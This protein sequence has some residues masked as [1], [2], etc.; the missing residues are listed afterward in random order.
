[1]SATEATIKLL[2]EIR[3]ELRK[4]NRGKSA[5]TTSAGGAG[6]DVADD[7]DLDSQYGDPEVK[8]DP[9]RWTGDR[10]AP[11]RMSE[12]SPDWLDALAGFCDWRAA[13]DD[14]SDALDTKGRPKSHWARKDAARAR[15][16]AARLR[17]SGGKPK[18]A[19]ATTLPNNGWGDSETSEAEAEAQAGQFDDV[20]F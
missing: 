13:K 10:F 11:C 4:L 5:A 20:G 16:W 18:P 14:E 8:K 19:Q 17:K 12:G 6:L 3:D 1:M 2:T 15:G 7:A 9:P